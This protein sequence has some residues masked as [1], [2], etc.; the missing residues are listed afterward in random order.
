[1]ILFATQYKN[2]NI[3]FHRSSAVSGDP[4]FLRASISGRLNIK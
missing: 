4:A 2:Y 1:M 3:A